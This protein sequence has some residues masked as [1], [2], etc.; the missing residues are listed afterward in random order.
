[1]EGAK[2]IGSEW[3]VGHLKMRSQDVVVFG[4]EKVWV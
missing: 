1:M 2:K 3:I 4:N